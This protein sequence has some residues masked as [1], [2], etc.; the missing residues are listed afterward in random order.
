MAQ[1]V[2]IPVIE[3]E[4]SPYDILRGMKLA[5]N[6]S[7]QYAIVGFPSIIRNVRLL[8]DLLQYKIDIYT[9]QKSDQVDLLLDTLRK[10]NYNMV[11][12]DM[13]TDT[14]ARQHNL[15]SILI[16]SGLESVESAI[17]QAVQISHS[18]KN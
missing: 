2:D 11:L 10:K 8:C 16:T 3:I 6:Y 14:H 1:A 12:C 18:F 9:W 7:G 17:D 5:E 13:I 15:N 4:T